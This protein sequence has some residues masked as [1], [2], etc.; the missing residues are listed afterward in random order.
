VS[1]VEMEVLDAITHERVLRFTPDHLLA[2]LAGRVARAE[3]DGEGVWV[4]T[5]VVVVDEETA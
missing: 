3:R 4:V 5:E 2:F 1:G